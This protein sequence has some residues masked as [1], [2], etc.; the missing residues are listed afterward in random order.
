MT[1]YAVAV[2]PMPQPISLSGSRCSS[3][4]SSWAVHLSIALGHLLGLVLSTAL[5][6]IITGSAVCLGARR[7][8]GACRAHQLPLA[9]HGA[10][11][12][13]L[14]AFSLDLAGFR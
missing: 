7:V 14:L 2:L 5:G 8:P 10:D 9:V 11:A 1:G 6:R 3:S 12:V 13:E 4:G